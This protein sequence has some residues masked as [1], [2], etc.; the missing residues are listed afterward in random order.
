MPRSTRV[1]GDI[2]LHPVALGALI[3][4]LANDHAWKG[5][6][7]GWVT[8]KV[9]DIVGLVVFPLLV[10]AIVEILRRRVGVAP[11]TMAFVACGT[12]LMFV[13]VKISPAVADA[14]SHALGIVMWP[15]RMGA[16]AGH[17]SLANA[18]RPVR[19]IADPSDLVALPALGLA[20]FIARRRC[21]ASP[22]PV[23]L[24]GDPEAGIEPGLGALP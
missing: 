6:F 23:V 24:R 14:Y 5:A 15:L 10:L 9:S 12:G 8:G 11:M 20:V 7:P 22:R 4:L 16:S 21:G 13:A 18:T 1:P 19:V 3:V 2:V 17:A